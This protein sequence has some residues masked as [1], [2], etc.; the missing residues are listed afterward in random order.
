MILKIFFGIFLVLLTT[1]SECSRILYIHPSLSRSHVIPSQA[2]AK[3]LAH[4]GHEITFISPYPI[5]KSVENFRDI[6]LEANE[7][8][9]KILNEMQKGMSE[10]KFTFLSMSKGMNMLQSFSNETLH[11][12][13]MKNLMKNEK[14]DLIIIGYVMNEFLLGLADHFKCPSIFFFP[15]FPL[16]TLDKMIGN[17]LS[18]EG[19]PNVLANLISLDTLKN[20]VINFIVS[21]VDL[22]LLRNYF[23]YKGKAMYE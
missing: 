2:L 13:E 15:A 19:Y 11:T 5:G 6:K 8:E 4:R 23:D 14:F 18:P 1:N 21:A 12:L 10:S 3:I 17:P 22:V 9:M 20:R 7:E 16:S